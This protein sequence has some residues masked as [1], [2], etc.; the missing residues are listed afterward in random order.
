MD[1]KVLGFGFPFYIGD[2]TASSVEVVALRSIALPDQYH[3]AE[4][5]LNWMIHEIAS[6]GQSLFDRGQNG[7]EV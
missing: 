4:R 7:S 1:G 2:K 6:E 3:V 5:I